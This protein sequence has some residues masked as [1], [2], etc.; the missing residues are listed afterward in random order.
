MQ[1]APDGGPGIASR[2]AYLPRHLS[3]ISTACV[4][5]RLASQFADRYAGHMRPTTDDHQGGSTRRLLPVLGL[6]SAIALVVGEVIG[7]GV[8]LKPNQVAQATGGYVGLILTLWLVCGLVNLCGALTLSELSAMMP[9]AGGTYVFLREAYG[10]L[11]AFLWGWAEFLVI[12]TGAIAALAAAMA[13]FLGQLLR[14]M[15]F[16][17]PEQSWRTTEKGI[18]VAAIALLATINIVGTHWGGTVQNITM[19]IKA[20]FLAF[21]AVLPLLATGSQSVDLDPLWPPAAGRSFWLGLGSALAGIMW[22]YDGWGQVTV[23]AEEI[24]NPHRNVPLAMGGGVL[25]LIVLYVGANLGFHLT[26]PSEAIARSEAPAVDVTEKLLPGIGTK[27]M[28]AMLMISVFGALNSNILVGPRV[29]FAVGRDHG[30][31]RPLRRIDPRFKTPALA[32]GALSSWSI[33]LIL[34]SDLPATIQHWFGHSTGEAP[35]KR[36]FDVLTDYTIFGGSLFYFAAVLAVFVL[37]R[38]RPDL[39][40]PYKTWGYPLVPAIFVVAYAFLLLSMFLAA[41]TECLSGLL[42]IAAGAVVYQ[43]ASRRRDR[44]PSG[45]S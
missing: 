16:A 6:F 7:S 35:P 30:F 45:N 13:I 21:L 20:A 34:A 17:L 29:L 42:L 26:L 28:T 3:A 14:Q 1:T 11:W 12:R 8:F 4:R 32:I 37:R 44:S 38:K 5:H 19:V 31:L 43:M 27:L 23:V 10:R 33:L 2:C 9:H 39:P 22:A 24:K 18:S 40:R 15:G 36:L 25:F 41:V